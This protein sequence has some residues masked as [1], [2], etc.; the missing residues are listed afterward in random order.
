MYRLAL[1]LCLILFWPALGIEAAPLSDRGSM[2]WQLVEHKRVDDG[3]H[4]AEYKL[5]LPDGST[6]IEGLEAFYVVKPRA[7]L[8]PPDS[9]AVPEEIYRPQLAGPPEAPV[10]IIYSGQSARVEVMAGAT[11]DGRFHLAR[12][13]LSTYGKSGLA[14]PGAQKLSSRPG[15]PDLRLV[16]GATYYRA[17]AGEELQFSLQG[18]EVRRIAVFEEGRL[19]ASEPLRLDNEH[20]SYTPPLDPPLTAPGYSVTRDL[21]FV[22]EAGGAVLSYY[23]PVGRSRYGR[24][25]LRPGLLTVA[26]AALLGLIAVAVAG[27]RFKWR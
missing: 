4:L 12:T 5:L 15:W 17:Q 9:P 16:S 14:D 13:F 18:L 7:G 21:V 3:G 2:R 27:R 8:R 26:S 11:I 22:A 24:L 25:Y 19:T 1:T 6:N 20:Y 23:L 10:L